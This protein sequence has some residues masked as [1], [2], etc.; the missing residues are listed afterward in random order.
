MISIF[1]FGHVEL[2]ESKEETKAQAMSK[3]GSKT[4]NEK[5]A[6]QPLSTKVDLKSGI[7][8]PKHI[9][10]DISE[11]NAKKLQTISEKQY[12]EK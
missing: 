10:V 8:S 5:M 2:N 1:T 6:G 3:R 12:L 4:L 11:T 7:V 9:D